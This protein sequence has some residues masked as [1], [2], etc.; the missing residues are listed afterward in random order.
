ML[1]F[2]NLKLKTKILWVPAG[3]IALT[4]LVM[5]IFIL[6]LILS[7]G[8]VDIIE[9]MK[10][11]IQTGLSLMTSTQLPADAYLALEGDDTELANELIQQVS[12]LGIDDLYI[13]DLDAGLLFA[14]NKIDANEFNAQ[15]GPEFLSDIRN[16]SRQR[17]VINLLHLAG[18]IIGYAP[19]ID[20]ETLNGFLIFVID[21]PEELDDIALSSF[22][23]N[24]GSG[25]N[26]E[27]KTVEDSSERLLKKV[28]YTVTA[29]LVPG[30]LLIC[31]I[32]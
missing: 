12:V 3:L 22:N 26:L 2:G 16:S 31:I 21:I 30:L 4:F 25:D 27:G 29:I 9:G 14:K 13:T 10:K 32:L 8:Q 23:D 24:T 5:G 7:N 19:I 1:N 18:H 6:N 15:F 20:V 28:L 11:Q 17:N